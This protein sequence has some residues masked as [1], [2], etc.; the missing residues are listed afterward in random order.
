MA[1]KSQPKHPIQPLVEDYHGVVRF[2]QN[3]IVNYLLKNGG[4]DLNKLAMVEFPKEDW[5]QF[6]Q[7][8]GYSH[9]GI[10]GVD[11]EIW[12]AAESM[13]KGGMSELEARNAHL[14]EE[15]TAL[16]LGI[17]D[18]VARLYNIHPDDL[19]IG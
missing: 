1:R 7:L 16:K 14:R 19:N 2:K 3:T 6:H 10:P 8:I 12:Q 9:S 17:K 11:E 15:L 13:Y 18:A 4:L 5:D